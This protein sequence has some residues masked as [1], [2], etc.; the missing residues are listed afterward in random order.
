MVIVTL[1]YLYGVQQQ[2][3]YVNIDMSRTDQSAYLNEAELLKTSNYTALTDRARM[4]IFPFL[5]SLFYEPN[6]SSGAFFIGEN[7]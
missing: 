1:L 3:L 7:F 4:P 5:L 2:F 6:L